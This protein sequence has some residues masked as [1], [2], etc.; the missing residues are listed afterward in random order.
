MHTDIR[1]HAENAAGSAASRAA[2]GADSQASSPAHSAPY[3]MEHFCSVC[4]HMLFTTFPGT[5][6]FPGRY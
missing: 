3:T 2:A 4:M 5:L 6:S 1:G